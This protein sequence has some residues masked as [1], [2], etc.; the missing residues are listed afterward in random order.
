MMTTTH[1]NNRPSRRFK[2]STML[3]LALFAYLCFMAYL[4]RG[5]FFSGEYLYYFGI[6]SVSIIVLILLHFSL[7]RKEAMQEKRKNDS[8]YGTYADDDKTEDNKA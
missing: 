7:K 2:R 4:G 1:N 5:Y 3:P 6:L 8:E